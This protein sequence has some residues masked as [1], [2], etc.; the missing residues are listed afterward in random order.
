MTLYRSIH[1]SIEPW[2]PQHRAFEPLNSPPQVMIL[3]STMEYTSRYAGVRWANDSIQ[4]LHQYMI[5]NSQRTRSEH[6][7]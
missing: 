7:T 3:N 6:Q 2:R 5:Q 1:S 4:T